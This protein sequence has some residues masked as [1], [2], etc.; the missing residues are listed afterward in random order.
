ML[1]PWLEIDHQSIF[2]IVRVRILHGLF[3][4]DIH[5]ADG[6]H[7]FDESLEIHQHIIVDLDPQEIFQGLPAQIMA[8][9][10]IGMVHLIPAMSGN[11]NQGIPR[12]RQKGRLVP[13]S[14]QHGDK[15]G[16]RTAGI[17]APPIHP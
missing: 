9:V 15:E 13:R 12:H 11:G 1:P 6:I 3:H 16:I 5:P 2:P 7:Q 14:I 4:I 17:S 10:G 8:S